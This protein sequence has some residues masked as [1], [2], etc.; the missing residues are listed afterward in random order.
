MFDL[1]II[2]N[3]KK[4]YICKNPIKVPTINFSI[5]VVIIINKY[6]KIDYYII[7]NIN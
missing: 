1:G 7:I 2:L 5:F 6:I 3:P 4:I